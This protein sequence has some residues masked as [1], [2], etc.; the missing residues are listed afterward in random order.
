MTGEQEA[1]LVI[2]YELGFT[3]KEKVVPRTV[4]KLQF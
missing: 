1:E 2:D 4:F 3:F